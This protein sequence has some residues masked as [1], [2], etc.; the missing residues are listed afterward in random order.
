MA[1]RHPCHQSGR[2]SYDG[3]VRR[4]RLII[5]L[6]VLLALAGATVIV[7]KALDWPPPRLL[8][9][10]GLPPAGGPTGRTEVVAGIEF[11]EVAPGYRY[12]DR[13]KAGCMKGDLVGRVFRGL[14]IS[15]GDPGTHSHWRCRYW[16]E[17]PDTI[18]VSRSCVSAA[19]M[20][21]AP[22]WSDS[23]LRAITETEWDYSV[24]CEAISV[25]S[26]RFEVATRDGPESEQSDPWAICVHP[27]ASPLFLAINGSPTHRLV[28][29]PPENP[30]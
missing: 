12:V 2:P 11:V 19:F 20:Q 29:L 21:N 16:T 26:D 4:R 7:W 6:V 27:T 10:Y 23:S 5:A 17:C 28:W 1:R 9:K 14:G 22:G 25:R 3:L 18:W 30:D 8:L 24:V 13:H 15:L